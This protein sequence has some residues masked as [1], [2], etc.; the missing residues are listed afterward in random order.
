MFV[1]HL[2]DA[3]N[4][5]SADLLLWRGRS[6]ISYAGR[7][8]YTHAELVVRGDRLLSMGMVWP[9]GRLAVL[10][11]LVRQ[12]PGR[13]DWYR[14][15]A[16][17]RFGLDRDKTVETALSCVG[18]PYGIANLAYCVLMRIPLLWR[19]FAPVTDDARVGF[20]SG[21]IC[22]EGVSRW[23]RAGGVDPVPH[24]AD[25]VTEPSDLSRSLLF[26]YSGTLV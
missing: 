24:L 19:L 4:M 21:M 5:S 23:L 10:A 14:T 17:G 16:D 6:I 3:V 8:C 7:G 26:R 20:L 22:S 15:D 2:S 11:D 13:I 25:C 9:R 12:S 1:L 18:K